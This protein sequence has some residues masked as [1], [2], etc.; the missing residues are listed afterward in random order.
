MTLTTDSFQ[1]DVYNIVAQV[2]YGRVITYGQIATLIGRPQNA[3]LVGYVLHGAAEASGLPCHRVVNA[4]GR[5]VPG[6]TAQRGL[7]ESEGIDKRKDLTQAAAGMFDEN[8]TQAWSRLHP[9]TWKISMKA[10]ITLE[11]SCR[12][13]FTHSSTFSGFFNTS[14]AYSLA[15]PYPV[16]IT[17]L[18]PSR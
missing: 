14:K 10:A 6:W 7:L 1:D 2:P 8:E 3:R 12:M 9:K 18:R 4:Q 13:F 16:L 11:R 15:F 17:R 5:L